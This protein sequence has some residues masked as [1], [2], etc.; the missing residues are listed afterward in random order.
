MT[1]GAT[2]PSLAVPSVHDDDGDG[3]LPDAHHKSLNLGIAQASRTRVIR[4]LVCTLLCMAAGGMAP[5]AAKDA[6]APAVVNAATPAANDAA[7]EPP[8]RKVL[9]SFPR[10]LD[11]AKAEDAAQDRPAETWSNGEIAAAQAR[12]A[13]I[14]KRIQAVATHQAP[15]KQGACGTPAPIELISIGRNPEVAISPPAVMTCELA[16]GIATWLKNDLQPLARKHLGAEIIKIE[17][18]S[19]YS[20]RNAYGRTSTR[21]SEHGL[22]NALDIRGFVTA[23]AK[24]AA[25]LEDWGTT[26]REVAATIA[27]A[28]A[29]ADKLAAD[30]AKLAAGGGA[31]AALRPSLIDRLPKFEVTVQIP[32]GKPSPIAPSAPPAANGAGLTAP[33]PPP[34]GAAAPSLSITQPDHLGG[35]PLPPMPGIVRRMASRSAVATDAPTGSKATFLRAAHA[36]ACEIFGTTLGPEANA[37]H[38]NHFH[39]DMAPRTVKKICE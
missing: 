19:S 3:A 16:E 36:A 39:V 6:D 32:G 5:A 18:M 33:T 28:K 34:T 14:L 37:A 24:T 20:C 25:V 21:L 11:E 13:E 12:C 4:A 26:Q 17:N 15:I 1:R 2:K 8:A 23:S 9:R 35:P 30:K 27:A 7:I 31:P 38:R 22:A 10:T 29:Q